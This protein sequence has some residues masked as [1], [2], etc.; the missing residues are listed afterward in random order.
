MLPSG[1]QLSISSHTMILHFKGEVCCK[2]LYSNIFE[3][4]P[5]DIRSFEYIWFIHSKIKRTPYIYKYSFD[6]GFRKWI[7]S[8]IH[9]PTK[10]TIRYTLLS[11]Q[12]V[13]HVIPDLAPSTALWNVEFDRQNYCGAN[14]GLG[15]QNRLKIGIKVMQQHRYLFHR[16]RQFRYLVYIS[17]FGL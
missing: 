9:S 14:W 12:K 11:A 1:A 4:S 10:M 3:Y 6:L 13:S 7:Y 2:F 8:N 15:T 16:I 17:F 5:T